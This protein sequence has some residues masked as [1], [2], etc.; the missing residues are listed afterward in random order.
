VK[1][2][3]V[4]DH[5][6]AGYQGGRTQLPPNRQ[7]LACAMADLVPPDRTAQEQTTGDLEDSSFRGFFD[8]HDCAEGLALTSAKK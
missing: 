3:T 8:F 7:L 2:V 4:R 5:A 1:Q 6:D